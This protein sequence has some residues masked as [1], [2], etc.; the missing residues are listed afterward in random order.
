[1]TSF[2]K[3][4]YLLGNQFLDDITAELTE[5]L[6]ATGVKVGEP[7][8]VQAAQVQ[9]GSVKVVGVNRIDHGLE[10]NLISGPVPVT[11]LHAG[12]GEA[13]R[14]TVGVMLPTVGALA[15][16]GPSE[17]PAPNDQGVVK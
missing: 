7:L 15:G 11:G 5:L 4:E 3:A 12:P 1:M 8:V 2:K 17:F 9:A 16:W 10:A 14:V 6:V 13:E